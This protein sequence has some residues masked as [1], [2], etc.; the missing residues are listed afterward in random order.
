[1]ITLL[2]VTVAS[3]E[4]SPVLYVNY[5]EVMEWD[6][7]SWRSTYILLAGDTLS[8]TTSARLVVVRTDSSSGKQ[9]AEVLID[10]VRYNPTLGTGV[11]WNTA[12]VQL[13]GLLHRVSIRYVDSPSRLPA[14][15]FFAAP[16]GS[17]DQPLNVSIPRVPG[18]TTLGLKVKVLLRGNDTTRVMDRPFFVLNSTTINVLGEALTVVEAIVPFEN[19]SIR[20]DFIK[21]TYS[22]LYGLQGGFGSSIQLP[23]YPERYLFLN[24]PSPTNLTSLNNVL[25][26]T[27]PKV[28]LA[29]LGSLGVSLPSVTYTV[30]FNV[31]QPSTLCG[32]SSISYRVLA[33]RVISGPSGR[34]ITL[35]GDNTTLV[36]RFFSRGVSLVDVVVSTPPGEL[37]VSPPIYSLSFV[38][39]DKMGGRVRNACFTVYS[40]GKVTA[41]GVVRDGEGLVCPLPPGEYVIVA[42]VANNVIARATVQVAGDTYLP[43]TTNTTSVQITLLREGT[44][45]LLGNYTITL[46]SNNLVYNA[47]GVGGRA[48]IEGVLPGVYAY[49][50]YISGDKVYEGKLEVS[51]TR[52]SFVFSIPVYHLRVQLVG[53]LNQPLNGLK[54]VLQGLDI[55]REAT[56]DPSGRVDLGLV[57]AGSYKLVAGEELFNVTIEADSFKLVQLNIVAVVY[58][59]KI[60]TGHVEFALLVLLLFSIVLAVRKIVKGF[61]RGESHIVEV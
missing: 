5:V 16:G 15:A 31:E 59:H 39:Y 54:V 17:T 29:A 32:T 37:S 33:P 49:S 20:G 6:G 51:D 38:L 10:G 57:P 53:A 11:L 28:L 14:L 42:Y 56:T 35:S 18:F 19:V 36:F 50:V 44:Q 61:K 9:P 30:N 23:P 24:S 7:F 40:T 52:N 45:E 21:A 58:G 1:M 48:R 4:A 34:S 46:R 27:P 41:S 47:T 26:G 12:L 60:T 55:K 3:I 13:D 25:K 2:I 8:F 22:Y 43:I